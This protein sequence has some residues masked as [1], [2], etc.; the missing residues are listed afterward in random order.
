MRQKWVDEAVKAYR[1]R[2][3]KKIQKRED[4]R[5]NGIGRVSDSSGTV[6]AVVAGAGVDPRRGR[7]GMTIRDAFQVRK[8][9]I[10]PN[11][12]EEEGEDG[13]DDDDDCDEG[14]AY[15]DTAGS[16]GVGG[17]GEKASGLTGETNAQSKKLFTM[18]VIFY[19]S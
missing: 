4:K 14:G 12:E 17:G 2:E 10:G 11:G 6:G 1:T 7:R 18:Y 15:E 16:A 3:E 9:R 19:F 5:G 13:E 8:S